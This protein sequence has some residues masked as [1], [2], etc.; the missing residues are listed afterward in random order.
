MTR[1]LSACRYLMLLPIAGCLLM[2]VCLVVIGIGR[3]GR[4]LTRLI[5]SGELSERSSKE[6]TLGAILTIDMFLVATATYLTAIGLYNLFVSSEPVELPARLNIR[7]LMDLKSK[8]ISVIVLALAISFLG[9]VI[10]GTDDLFKDGLGIALIVVALGLF[11]FFWRL[12]AD[13][14]H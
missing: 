5:M 10:S 2:N 6:L 3:L 14:Q 4:E 12:G 13:P 7:S 11:L 1:L 8:L 9:K